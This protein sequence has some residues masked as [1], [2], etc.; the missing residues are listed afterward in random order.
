MTQSK[1]PVELVKGEAQ[2]RNLW[3]VTDYDIGPY[4]AAWINAAEE[5]A[6]SFFASKVGMIAVGFVIVRWGGVNPAQAEFLEVVQSSFGKEE[7]SPALYALNV[8]EGHQGQGHAS[9]LLG[10]AEESI[11][12]RPEVANR[13]VIAVDASELDILDMY[14]R[15]GYEVLSLG[16]QTLFDSLT[17]RKGEEVK[18][19]SHFMAK[20]LGSK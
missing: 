6:I 12:Q 9:G 11:V 7:V 14:Q 20:D 19:Q 1:H 13:A 2:L 15:R 18:V 17:T 10:V 4:P 3:N 8:V 5:D 16:G